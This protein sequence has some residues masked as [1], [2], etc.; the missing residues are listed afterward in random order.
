MK[1]IKQDFNLFSL[2]SCFSGGAIKMIT[3]ERQA[4]LLANNDPQGVLLKR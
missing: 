3:L 1:V 2:G 4:H